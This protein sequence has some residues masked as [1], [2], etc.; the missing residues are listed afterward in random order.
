ML[1][2]CVSTPDPN[3]PWD[4]YLYNGVIDVPSITGIWEKYSNK[5]LN[6]DLLLSYGYGD[7]GG[8]PNRDMVEMRR[9]IDKIPGIPTLNPRMRRRIL[10]GF[11]KQ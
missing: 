10:I 6:H 7:G 4:A 5:D 1:A 8:G 11:T 3:S 2:H 9:R